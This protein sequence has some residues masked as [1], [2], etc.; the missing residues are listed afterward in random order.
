[1]Y[2]KSGAG[3]ENK[4]SRASAE[5][6]GVHF[7]G[8]RQI[9]EN[10]VF[11]ALADAFI[12]PSSWEEWGL[13]VNEAMACSL[14]VIVSQTVGCAEDLLAA[15]LP[16][17]LADL[18]LDPPVKLVPGLRQNGF[19]FDPGS[20]E[21]LAAALADLTT[22]PQLG[23][24]MGQASRQIVQTVSCDVFAENA[25]RA[26]QVALGEDPALLPAVAPCM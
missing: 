4:N 7:Y 25:L 17:G 9:E 5:V 16:P 8:F 3:G 26:A 21:S 2:D 13:V 10:P 20:P 19:V 11:Y 18:R 6:P 22:H 12:L 14:P 23:S 24:T 15:G 1:V